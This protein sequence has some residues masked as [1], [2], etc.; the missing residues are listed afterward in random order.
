M[1]GVNLTDGY[2]HKGSPKDAEHGQKHR[3]TRAKIRLLLPHLSDG[4]M[5]A[6]LLKV[7]QRHPD[8]VLQV[9]CDLID[10]NEEKNG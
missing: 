3:H 6:V 8:T 7:A 9:M 1:L 2:W 4:D 10:D 5:E